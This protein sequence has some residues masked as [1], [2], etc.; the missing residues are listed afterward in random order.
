[1]NDHEI[2]LIMVVLFGHPMNAKPIKC[3]YM[4]RRKG[5]LTNRNIFINF[6]STL[7]CATFGDKQTI[8]QRY[9]IC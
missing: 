9:T 3:Q 4:Y 6:L 2:G 7:I 8:V 1:M 5:P